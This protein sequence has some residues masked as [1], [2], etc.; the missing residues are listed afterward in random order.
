[1]YNLSVIIPMYNAADYIVNCVNAVLSQDLEGIEVIIVNDC[2]TDESM[3]ICREHFGGNDNVILINQPSNMGPGQARNTGIKRARGKYVTFMDSDDGLRPGAYRAM[4]EA[5]QQ[6]DADVLHVT[7]VLMQTVDEAPCDLNELSED[8]VFRVTLDEGPKINELTVLTVD[9]QERLSKWLLHEI[10]W[11]I[12]NKLYKRDFLLC[13]D[14][15]FGD[16]KFAEDQVFSFR[17]LCRADKYVMLPGEWYMYRIGSESLSRGRRGAA[18]MIKA[19]TSQLNMPSCMKAAMA[20]VE[21]FDNNPAAQDKA[22]RYVFDALEKGFIIPTF[23]DAGED[24]LRSDAALCN[25]FTE[26]FGDNSYFAEN[27]FYSAHANLPAGDNI[28]DMITS[29][30]FWRAMKEKQTDAAK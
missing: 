7:G 12:W 1:M 25:V 30:A 3:N 15:V 26:Y 8:E 18:F 21:Y 27:Q 22:I 14:I 5:A 16:M 2:S 13:N 19:L 4:Y 11:S 20:G 6:K 24:N 17:C 10:H 29:P 28:Y 23:K 9:M